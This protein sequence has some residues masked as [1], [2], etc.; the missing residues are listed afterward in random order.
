MSKEEI[1]LILDDFQNGKSQREISRKRG[2]S[3][4]AIQNILK[5]YRENQQVLRKKGSG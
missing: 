3:R 2:R 5:E 1:A 4:C